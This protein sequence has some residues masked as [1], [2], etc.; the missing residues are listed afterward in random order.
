MPNII[1][2]IITISFAIIALTFYLVGFFLF[3]RTRFTSDNSTSAYGT[4]VGFRRYYTTDQS[5][6]NFVDYDD[7][8]RGR[9]PIFIIKVNGEKLEISS[10][11]ANYN[12]GIEDI[13]KQFRIRYR[14]LIGIKLITDDEKSIRHYNQIQNTLFWILISV[15][16]VFLILGLGAYFYLPQVISKATL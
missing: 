8:K 3:K 2:Q 12:L 4:L 6:D 1:T 15:A 7:N 5:G 9:V 13:G 14:R 16:T 10:A 11:I